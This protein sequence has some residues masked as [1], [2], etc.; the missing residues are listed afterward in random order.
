MFTIST[1][2]PI[3]V[4]GL[5]YNF[6]LQGPQQVITLGTEDASNVNVRDRLDLL[7][8]E[9]KMYQ[10]ANGAQLRR[11]QEQAQSQQARLNDAVADMDARLRAIEAKGGQQVVDGV[12]PNG[13]GQTENAAIAN[14]EDGNSASDRLSEAKLGQWMEDALQSGNRDRQLTDRA[15]EQA[16]KSL[17]KVRGILLDDIQCGDIF[18]RATFSQANGKEPDI[19]DVLGKPPFSSGGFTLTEPDGHVILYFTQPGES[20]DELRNRAREELVN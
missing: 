11:I 3:T 5:L 9:L 14:E 4:A 2:L 8:S 12:A 16:L 10:Q 17:T 13:G 19:G 20:L 18:C 1:G 6:I 15:T 7:T